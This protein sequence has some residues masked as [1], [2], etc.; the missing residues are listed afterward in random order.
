MP[1][2][3]LHPNQ[4]RRDWASDCRM[5]GSRDYVERQRSTSVASGA[6]RTLT[7]PRL[8]KPGAYEDT[9]QPIAWL[10]EPLAALAQDNVLATARLPHHLSP[11][12]MYLNVDPVVNAV[13]IGLV[14]LRRCSRNRMTDAV[15]TADYDL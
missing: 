1:A 4:H 10:D 2:S 5:T 12:G 14:S 7:E 8:Q 3:C 9:S 11:W 6:K 15:L 13:L